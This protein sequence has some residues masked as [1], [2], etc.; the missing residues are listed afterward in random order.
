M[1][2]GRDLFLRYVAGYVVD[3]FEKRFGVSRYIWLT[4]RCIW[5]DGEKT[6]MNSGDFVGSAI[7]LVI[8]KERGEEG[9]LD[10]RADR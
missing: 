3:C 10:G 7:I 8:P 4:V 2:K 6:K 5:E 9:E 1:Q